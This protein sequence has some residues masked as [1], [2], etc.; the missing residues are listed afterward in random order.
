[1]KCGN[2]DPIDKGKCFICKLSKEHTAENCPYAEAKVGVVENQ[3]YENTKR[4]KRGNYYY[5]LW[6]S[7]KMRLFE[8]IKQ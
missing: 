6:I 1:M 3:D 5:R 7:E 2:I 8:Q 4:S